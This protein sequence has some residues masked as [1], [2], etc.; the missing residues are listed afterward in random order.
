MALALSKGV[1]VLNKKLQ[2]VLVTLW[3]PR[4]AVG[5]WLFWLDCT[6]QCINLAPPVL[7]QL[8]P[9][10]WF[11][12]LD[13]NCSIGR[14]YS[15]N[16]S[17]QVF[18]KVIGSQQTNNLGPWFYIKRLRKFQS[19]LHV[20][21]APS[22]WWEVH[23]WWTIKTRSITLAYLPMQVLAYNSLPHSRSQTYNSWGDGEKERIAG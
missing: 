18:F 5:P 13:E 9:N 8:E 21:R 6:G 14:M 19:S 10:F 16:P 15:L 22:V 17:S 7:L 12:S 20:T 3:S 11:T 23:R 2:D 4:T 1:A